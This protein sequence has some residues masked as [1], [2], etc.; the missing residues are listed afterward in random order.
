MAEYSAIEDV[1]VDKSQPSNNIG[2]Y[3]I[4][5]RFLGNKDKTSLSPGIYII[6]GSKVVV[7]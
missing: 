1:V 7:K 5:G 3:T 2:I 6:N 4:D